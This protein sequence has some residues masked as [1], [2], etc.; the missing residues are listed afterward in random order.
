[1]NIV[2]PDGRAFS[3]TPRQIVTGMRALSF[4]PEIGLREFIETAAARLRTVEGLEIG[5]PE[6]DDEEA[7]CAD[8]IAKLEAAGA[9]VRGV[10][11]TIENAPEF[12]D[13]WVKALE[14]A[15]A[16]SDSNGR[17]AEFRQ[18]Y[19]AHRAAGSSVRTAL[20]ATLSEMGLA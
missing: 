11:G 3:G 5:T 12:T 13:D 6:G 20:E 10:N 18:R 1:M 9:V 15:E 7:L 17:L 2:T 14:K 19:E 16:L 8:F 4:Y